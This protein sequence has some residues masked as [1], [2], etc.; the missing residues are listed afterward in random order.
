MHS[1]AN[2]NQQ[3][4]I[5]SDMSIGKWVVPK[6]N[7][8]E[9]PSSSILNF[10]FRMSFIRHIKKMWNSNHEIITSDNLKINF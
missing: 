7:N 10:E 5:K 9:Q 6:K 2:D 3:N 4:K 1:Q 8:D